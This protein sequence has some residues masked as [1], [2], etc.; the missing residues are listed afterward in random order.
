M[1][2]LAS[3]PKP[4]TRNPKSETSNYSVLPEEVEHERVHTRLDQDW[5]T[6]SENSNWLFLTFKVAPASQR[7]S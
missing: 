7:C 5:Y 2:R 3:N 1:K 4:E 6:V